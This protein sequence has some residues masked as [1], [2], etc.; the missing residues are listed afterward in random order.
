[1]TRCQMNEIISW[2]QDEIKD[3][4]KAISKLYSKKKDADVDDEIPF[5]EGQHFTYNVV[6]QKLKSVEMGRLLSDDSGHWYLVP[7]EK[8]KLFYP[9]LELCTRGT[10][11]DEDRQE[12]FINAFDEYRLSGGI[13]DLEIPI[14][15]GMI[16]PF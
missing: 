7:V 1:V 9:M 8:S 2:L 15:E 14:M 11:N 13:T 3:V 5:L 16:L 12:E 10:Y 4:N 6:L